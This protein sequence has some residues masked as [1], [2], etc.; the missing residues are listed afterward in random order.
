MDSVTLRKK[1]KQIG[2]SLL[3]Q[4]NPRTEM[5]PHK[6]KIERRSLSGLLTPLFLNTGSGVRALR[7]IVR[8]RVTSTSPRCERLV[9]PQGKRGGKTMKL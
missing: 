1:E 7:V 4:E 3:C 9:G 8:T 5:Y 2:K 6:V